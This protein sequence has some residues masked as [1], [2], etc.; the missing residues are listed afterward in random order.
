MCEI[1]NIVY[2]IP[3]SFTE[4]DLLGVSVSFKL[5]FVVEFAVSHEKQQ[6][7]FDTDIKDHNK[8]T[9]YL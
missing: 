3:D 4:G 1:L 6:Q 2:Q 9:H 8:N 7:K 5:V